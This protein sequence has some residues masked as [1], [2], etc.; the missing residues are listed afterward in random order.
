ME[1]EENVEYQNLISKF[2]AGDIKFKD[3]NGDGKI[4]RGSSTLAD[5]GDLKVIGNSTPRYCYGFRADAEW[6]GIDLAVFF[7]G[8]GRRDIVPNTIYFLQHYTSEWAVPQKI[9]LDYWSPDNPD[10]YFPRPRLGDADEI[11][12][13]Q[14]RFL[15]NAAYIRLKQLT[16]GYSI[17]K[18]LLEKVNIS[19]IRL[20]FSFNNL[21]EYTKMLKIFDPETNASNIYPLTRSFSM[22]IDLTF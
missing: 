7:Q 16:L 5:H 19:N 12:T 3:L 8:V 9:N 11:T 13:P 14:S 10:A 18:I 4:T 20:Y 17:P 15:Q 6:K 21:W 1:E 22:G 2:L